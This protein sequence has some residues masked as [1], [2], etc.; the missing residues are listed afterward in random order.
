MK[1]II[2]FASLSFASCAFAGESNKQISTTFPVVSAAVQKE[3]DEMRKQILDQE[4]AVETARLAKTR[5]ELSEATAAKR[6]GTD[7]AALKDALHRHESNIA[8]LNQELA[9]MS[10]Q[11]KA[12]TPV[13][14][15]FALK[16]ATS[17]SAAP[18]APVLVSKYDGYQK[19]ADQEDDP[20]D[21]Y[22]ISSSE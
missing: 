14:D 17:T 19:S 6:T 20:Y 2:I 4:L 5:A 12:S 7:I 8:S 15:A 3:R 16:T 1:I 13:R 9:R 22:A 10:P 11:S 18:A 21:G